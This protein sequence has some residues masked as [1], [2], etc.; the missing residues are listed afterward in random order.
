MIEQ[1]QIIERELKCTSIHL[2]KRDELLLRSVLALPNDSS[3]GL[4]AMRRSC[5]PSM[6]D[7]VA[8]AKNSRHFFVA[9]V[10]PAPDSPEMMMAWLRRSR[11]PLKAAAAMP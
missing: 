9:S 11:S 1:P 7:V 8:L 4:P 6:T 5:R 10:L 2:P 3:T